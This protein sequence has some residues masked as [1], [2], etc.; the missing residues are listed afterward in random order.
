MSACH[1]SLV[2]PPIVIVLLGNYEIYKLF[3]FPR[4]IKN[5]SLI[6]E[7]FHDNNMKI[8]IDTKEDSP[9][10]IKK[11]ITMLSSLIHSGNVF[12]DTPEN[13]SELMGLFDEK[14]DE[15]EKKEDT[16]IVEYD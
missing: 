16:E 6:Y 5:K 3:G 7:F 9:E 12:E 11:V 13:T 14:K 8:T 10:E 4:V 1:A 15:E 2:T